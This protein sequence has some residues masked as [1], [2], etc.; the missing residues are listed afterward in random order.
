MQVQINGLSTPVNAVIRANVEEQ[1]T[2]SL[3]R[4]RH[5]IRGVRV[6]LDVNGGQEPA[7]EKRCTLEFSLYPTGQLVV[8]GSGLDIYAAVNECL[9]DGK[10]SIKRHFARMREPRRVAAQR[11]S[12]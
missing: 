3:Q 11:M 8:V 2:S 9:A 1:V 7:P 12:A 10:R 6:K 5:Y 4:L